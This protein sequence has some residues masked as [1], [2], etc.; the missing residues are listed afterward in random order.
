MDYYI[1][2]LK[3]EL[4]NIL[5]FWQENAIKNDRFATQVSIEGNANFSKPLGTLYVSRILYGAS[6]A[7]LN[8]KLDTYKPMADLAYRV[9][10][11]Q[12]TNPNG[13]YYWAVDE[14]AAVVH[15]P[16]NVSLSQAFVIYGLGEYYALTADPDVK[17]EMFRQIDF[18]ES[19][20][21]NVHDLSYMDGFDQDWNPLDTQYKSLGTHIHL[22][23]AYT[24][25]LNVT[26]DQI[27]KR[28]VQQLIE[29]ILNKFVNSQS[30]E[31]FHQFDNNWKLSPNETWIGHNVETARILYNSATTI[32]NKELIKKCQRVLVD[33]CDNAIE[34]GF[35]T[36]YGGMFSRFI[37]NSPVSSNKEWWPQ[38]ECVLAFLTC[39]NFTYDKKLLSYAIRLLEYI[40]NT[41]SDARRGE[42]YDTVTREGKPLA[43]QPKLH[44]WKSMYHNVRYCIESINHFEKMFVNA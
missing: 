11:N 36:K 37:Q 16:I 29:V 9:L 15:D 39:Y 43:D 40:D 21:R 32:K 35:D 25:F 23:E 2:R 5:K 26:G 27:Y 31:V 20:I 24:K 38:A 14:N 8:L 1:E 22:L 30:T 7:T 33:I 19:K 44:L 34:K 4:K 42:W 17:K 13:G 10:R 3:D 18:I 41:F 28:S 12:L 6:A